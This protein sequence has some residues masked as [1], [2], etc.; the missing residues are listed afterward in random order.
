MLSPY[1]P[2]LTIFICPLFET[3]FLSYT[4]LGLCLDLRELLVIIQYGLGALSSDNL[5]IS[6]AFVLF[7]CESYRWLCFFGVRFVFLVCSWLASMMAY[8]TI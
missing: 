3:I 7:T 4:F 1:P 2:E 5:V 8:N 6:Y